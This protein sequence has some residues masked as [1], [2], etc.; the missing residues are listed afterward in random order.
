MSFQIK[1]INQLIMKTSTRKELILFAQKNT[2][3]NQRF[4]DFGHS[5]Q[6]MK[7]AEKIYTKDGGDLDIIIPAALFHDISNTDDVY[8]SA[9]IAAKI[10]NVVSNYPTDKIKKVGE[11]IINTNFKTNHSLETLITNDTDQLSALTELGLFRSL[12]INSKKGLSL[13][14]AI[15]DINILTT[16]KY[17]SFANTKKQ[18]TNYGRILADRMYSEVRKILNKALE[19]YTIE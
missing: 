14:E 19:D 2:E 15:R 5:M 1:L 13:L 10:L 4:H 6:V 8:E 18:H 3:N 9:E 7:I 11:V 17:Q 16:K 12:M